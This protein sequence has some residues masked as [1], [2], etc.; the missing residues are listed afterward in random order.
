MS[1]DMLCAALDSCPSLRCGGAGDVTCKPKFN[2]LHAAVRSQPVLVRAA[3]RSCTRSEA[4][5]RAPSPRRPAAWRTTRMSARRPASTATTS[6]AARHTHTDAP[7]RRN[8]RRRGGTRRGSQWCVCLPADSPFGARL[9]RLAAPSLAQTFGLCLF[10][11]HS[12]GRPAAPAG[13]R[14]AKNSWRLTHF[15]PLCCMLPGAHRAHEAPERGAQLR[16]PGWDVPPLPEEQRQHARL[17]THVGR[18]R[19]CPPAQEARLLPRGLPPP[20]LRPPAGASPGQG[21]GNSRRLG[22]P[23]GGGE[24]AEQPYPQPEKSAALRRHLWPPHA[25][26]LTRWWC[27]PR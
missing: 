11:P 19:L 9:P 21:Q 26:S 10:G 17:H 15:L 13:R 4:P 8:R 5:V 6:S 24:E 7:T 25:P 12:R 27:T 16:W 3:A 14:S 18:L 2:P 1:L 23:A 22:A 20:L